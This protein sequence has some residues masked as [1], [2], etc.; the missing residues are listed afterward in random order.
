MKKSMDFPEVIEGDLRSL[1]VSIF[2]VERLNANKLWDK[3]LV[4]LPV[5]Q[6]VKFTIFSL[7][8]FGA[9]ILMR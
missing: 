6:L 5:N 2:V 8:G 4:N 7:L 3:L 9:F 1:H